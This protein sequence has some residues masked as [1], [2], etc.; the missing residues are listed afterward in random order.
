M[1]T[2]REQYGMNEVTP[3]K[4]T[5]LSSIA[6][7]HKVASSELI[8]IEVEVEHVRDLEGHPNKVWTI[9]TDGSLRNNGHEFIT[10]PIQACSAPVVL[11]YLMGTYLPQDSC[12]SPRTSV[13]VHLN[14]QD[15]TKAQVFDYTMLYTVF[16][17]LFYRFAGR[18]RM[19]NIYCVPL[20]DSALGGRLLEKNIG[21]E[22]W[23]KYT[24]LNLLP[25]TNYGTIEWRHMHGTRDVG[26]LCV[27]IN[28][29][30][31]LKEYIKAH[32]TAEI[33]AAIASMSDEFDFKAL[34]AD[35]FG[36]NSAHLK[37]QS[38]DDVTYLS[39]KE[40]LCS[41]TNIIK[42]RAGYSQSSDFH[43]FKEQ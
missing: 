18:G 34:L 15:F 22:T 29:I 25:L 17:K 35:I 27:W 4:V 20:I 37:F 13:H 28:L 31:S 39:A 30:T 3:H 8:G 5:G 2:I 36:E 33:R 12:F 11:Q 24:G 19:K 16:E 6:C 10:R 7:D 32:G 14:M 42:A 41:S 38:L 21:E 1:A 40:A 9:T 43:K 26:K 23:S